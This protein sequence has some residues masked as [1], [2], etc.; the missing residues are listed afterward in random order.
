MNLL[1]ANTYSDWMTPAAIRA[2]LQPMLPGTDIRCWPDDPGDLAAVAMLVI[3]DDCRGLLP[4]LPQLRL[5]QKLGAGVENVLGDP[6]L[7]DGI[8]IARLRAGA[9]AQEMAEYCLAFVMRE[10][11]LLRVYADRQVR[12]EWAS[13]DP[14]LTAE[15]SVGILGLGHTGGAAAR[16]F[17]SV[18]FRVLGWSR[19]PKSIPQVECRH[20][21]DALLPFLGECDHVCAVLPSTPETR[22]LMN[23]ERFGAMRQG[24]LFVNVGRGDL[25]DDNA[26]LAGLAAGKPAQAALDVFNKEPL[27]ADHPFWGH[28]QVSITPHISGWHVDG[29]F[30][31]IAENWRRLQAGELPLNEI[32]RSRGY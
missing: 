21:P 20:G 30:D 13:T 3:D 32:D 1:I 14:P 12:R 4:K 8:A 6:D 24:S 25:V 23:A 19:S 28:P 15:A 18:G 9:A 11:R 7:R 26:L 29:A 22:G 31:S 17:A 2:R 16:L 10:H 5:I 27:P